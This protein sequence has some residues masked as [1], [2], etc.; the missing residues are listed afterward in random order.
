MRRIFLTALT[1]SFL[2]NS[3]ALAAE[4]EVRVIGLSSNSGDVHIAVYDT[5]E[6]FPDS[7][8]MLTET[9]VPIADNQAVMTFKD[10]KP[11]QYA[12]AVYHDANG[13]HDFDQGIFG[14]P[15]ED[16]GFSNDARVFFAPPS[17]SAAAIDVSEP[18]RSITIRLND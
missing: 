6:K 7:D 16:Y 18:G 13:N 17:F 14:L 12:V 8:G 11:G 9:H 4:L 3:A 2:G 5:P 1:I 10:L 15:L